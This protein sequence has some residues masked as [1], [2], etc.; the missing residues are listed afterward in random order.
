MNRRTAVVL[1]AAFAG[2]IVLTGCGSVGKTNN[3]KVTGMVVE[4]EQELDKW[5]G[6][7]Y[8]LTIT[9]DRKA[10]RRKEARSGMK[11]K[12]INVSNKVYESC[13][14]KDMYKNGNC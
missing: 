11:T 8:Q 13:G 9:T 12:E 3:P 4:R 5:G 14:L 1:S 7:E 6:T 10:I 2:T